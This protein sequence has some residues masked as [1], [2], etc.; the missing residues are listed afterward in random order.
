MNNGRSQNQFSG[1]QGIEEALKRLNAKM[2]YAGMEPVELVSCGGAS[3]NLMGWVSRST[4]DVDIIC[5]AQVDW[6]LSRKTSRD[7]RRKLKDV[8][9][10]IGHEKLAERLQG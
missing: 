5:E 9:D 2:V 7:F 4:S 10:R 1:R 3:L 6:L 8:L